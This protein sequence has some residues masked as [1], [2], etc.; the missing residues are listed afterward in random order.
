MLT[1]GCWLNL[2][3]HTEIRK[4]NSIALSITVY[5]ILLHRP[6]YFHMRAL[7]RIATHQPRFSIRKSIVRLRFPRVESCYREFSLPRVFPG[8]ASDWKEFRQ[9]VCADQRL[10]ADL[11]AA[12]RTTGLEVYRTS[13]AV[14][15]HIRDNYIV[16]QHR[17]VTLCFP[18]SLKIGIHA[19]QIAIAR[20]VRHHWRIFDDPL[21]KVWLI[22]HGAFRQE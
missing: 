16:S 4:N 8:C 20:V 1:Q 6:V 12:T 18:L 17:V 2:E 3:R 19:T 15:D 5:R 21:K 22:P 10:S 14:Y 7:S 11:R 9:V 13:R